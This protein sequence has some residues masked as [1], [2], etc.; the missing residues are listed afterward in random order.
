M[1]T[2]IPVIP[3]HFRSSLPR[4][5]REKVRI[6]WIEDVYD[7]PRNGV[8]FCNSNYCWF[9]ALEKQK[10]GEILYILVAL[11]QEKYVILRER[12]E[13]FRSKVGTHWDYDDNGNYVGGSVQPIELHKEYYEQARSWVPIDIS[14]NR[15]LGWFTD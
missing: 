7:Y 9:E 12:N 14:R 3:S 10:N 8:A 13:L 11:K 5:P 1:T 6:L 15:I 2:I 4:I